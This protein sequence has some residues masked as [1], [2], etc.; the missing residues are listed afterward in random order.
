MRVCLISVYFAVSS[1]AELIEEDSVTLDPVFITLIA[2]GSVGVVILVIFVIYLC[3]AYYYSKRERLVRQAPIPRFQ[4]PPPPG[5]DESQTITMP[6]E[7]I[8]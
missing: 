4:L 6:I 7:Y 1:V 2:I 3:G 8:Q 5:P